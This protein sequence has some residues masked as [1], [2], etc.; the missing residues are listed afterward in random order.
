MRGLVTFMAIAGIGGSLFLWQKQQ[1]QKSQVGTTEAAA[2]PPDSTRQTYEHD[3]AKHSLDTTH[4]VI[5][6]IKQRRKDD[7]LKEAVGRR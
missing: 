6:K 7:D 4:A 1:E 5:D 2:Q 3:W